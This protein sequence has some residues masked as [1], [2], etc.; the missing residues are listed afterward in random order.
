LDQKIW[1]L[2]MRAASWTNAV[3]GEPQETVEDTW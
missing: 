2:T 1:L 3:S